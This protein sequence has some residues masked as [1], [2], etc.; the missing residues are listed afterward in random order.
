[1]L[2]IATTFSAHLSSTVSKVTSSNKTDIWRSWRFGSGR[3][4]QTGTGVLSKCSR[5][6]EKSNENVYEGINNKMGLSPRHGNSVRLGC[7][8]LCNLSATPGS[9]SQTG[10]VRGVNSL[11]VLFKN[12]HLNKVNNQEYERNKI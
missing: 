12:P 4:T 7:T 8:Q 9:R 3:V 5:F 6:K 11:R 10:G 1:M 2:Q